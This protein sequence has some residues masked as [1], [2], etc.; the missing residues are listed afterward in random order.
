MNPA[1]MNAQQ[2]TLQQ[3]MLKQWMLKQRMLQQRMLQQRML[4][5]R[6]LQQMLRQWMLEEE[7]TKCASS[8]CCQLL[9]GY[10]NTLHIRATVH[11]HMESG[12][13]K[14]WATWIHSDHKGEPY[15][16]KPFVRRKRE[17]LTKKANTWA[18]KGWTNPWASS[19]GYVGVLGLWKLIFLKSLPHSLCLW[20]AETCHNGMGT[21]VGTHMQDNHNW[22]K[23][24]GELAL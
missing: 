19:Q 6:M 22:A 15:I 8:G 7:D 24:E 17:Y 20:G 1:T 10:V 11:F 14:P 21:Y 5:Q 18:Q 3:R 12:W 2:W 4:Q 23:Y 13:V 9:P 16:P